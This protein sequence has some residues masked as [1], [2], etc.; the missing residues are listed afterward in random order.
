[1]EGTGP[2]G[3]AY[4]GGHED[5]SPHSLCSAEAEGRSATEGYGDGRGTQRAVRKY[6]K[7]EDAKEGDREYRKHCCAKR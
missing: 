2:A 6:M 3:G 1:M 7:K 5:R 4:P